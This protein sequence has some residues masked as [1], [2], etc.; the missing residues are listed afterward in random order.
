MSRLPLLSLAGL[1]VLAACSDGDPASEAG[2]E[3]TPTAAPTATPTT[4]PT[5]TPTIAEPPVSIE[6]VA[7]AETD[8]AWSITVD[9]MAD[10]FGGA[11]LDETAT[12]TGSPVS[13]A[14]PFGAFGSCSGQRER[15]GTYSVLVSGDDGIDAVSIWTADRVDAAGTYD[16]E[17]RIERPGSEPIAASG[18]LTILDGLQR[19]EFAAT[20][21]EG[22][23]VEGTFA[24]LGTV[25]PV[26]LPADA[27]L[28]DAVVEAV[29]VYALLRDGGAERIVGL[30]ADASSGAAC[31]RV[32]GRADPSIVRV[33][34]DAR[35]G[36]ITEF[37]LSGETSTTAWLRAGGVGFDL[38]DVVLALDEG[39]SSGVFSG[40][41][42][43]GVTVDGA[44]RCS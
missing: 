6:S 40:V 1:L 10:G 38:D 8:T 31:P 42:V 15:L 44:F 24:C 21:P 28:D 7:G 4:T 2:N 22:G 35:V 20:G 16:A 19:G 29:E 39:G 13:D 36:G 26:P 27:G 23:R 25:P 11:T 12:W 18:T 5:T 17:V 3:P 30:T 34:G 37:E 43:D 14:G 9:V 32:E 41:T 33:E